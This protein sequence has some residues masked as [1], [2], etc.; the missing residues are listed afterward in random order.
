MQQE[1]KQYSLWMVDLGDKKYVKGHEQYG[2]RPFF[3]ISST[4]YNKNSKTP[5]GF[6][7]STSEKKAQNKYSLDIDK[8]G[9]INI[10]QIRTLSQ[11]RFK[12]CI[13]EIHSSDLEAKIL[14]TF[15]NQIILNGKFDDDIFIETFKEQGTKQKI[16]HLFT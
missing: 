9:S 1:I 2:N 15:I 13:D 4:E 7:A 12:K 6:F 11:E 10:S 16:A 14:S 8:K 5:I 3:V